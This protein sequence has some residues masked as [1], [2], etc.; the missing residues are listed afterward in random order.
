[1]PVNYASGTT[2]EP[3]DARLVRWTKMLLFFQGQAGAD[4][5]NDPLPGDSLRNILVKL[6][7]AIN[8]AS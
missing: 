5:T 8:H 4:P 6:L 7:R 1:M 3:T 2:P